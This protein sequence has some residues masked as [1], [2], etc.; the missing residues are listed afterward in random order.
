MR[1]LVLASQS[2]RRKEL[3][4]KAGFDFI[5]ASLEISE[6][7]NENLSLAEQ[8]EDLARQKAEALVASPKLPKLNNILIISAD[9]V[10][11][12]DGE[13][14]GKP[15]DRQESRHHLGRLS[16]RIHQVITGVCVWDLDTQTKVVTH[17]KADVKFRKLSEQEMS[18]YVASG[19]GMDKAGA[20]GIQGVGG[21][22]IADLQGSFD[23]VMGL[24]VALIEKI[25]KEKNWNVR[26]NVSRKKSI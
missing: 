23:N 14:I 13:I 16:G 6:I 20:Y 12:V 9:T 5:V 10:V 22:F 25:I 7:P 19:E 26:R 3:L 21:T 4:E 1:N 17:E 15:R 11:I 24:P 18:D 8:I 2:P